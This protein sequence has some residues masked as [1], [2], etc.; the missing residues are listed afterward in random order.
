MPAGGMVTATVG[1]AVIG[2]IMGNISASSS[3]K[4]AAAASRAALAE[5]N[6]I[7]MPPDLSKEIIMK[8]FESQGILTPD[9]EQEI[10]LQASEVSQIKED[11]S[12]RGAQ[13]E[14]L[15]T[16]GQ[17]SRGGLQAGDRQAY[18]EL[19]ASTQRDAEAKRQ[20]ILQQMQM[21]GQG[22]SGASLIAQLQSGQAAEDTA[23]MQGDRLAAQAS[24]NALAALSQRSNLASGMRTQD[25]SAA[26]MRARAID[27]RNRFLAENSVSRQRAN[28]GALN[29][30]QQANLAN[31]QRLSE[32]NTSQANT[33]A[34]RQQQAKRDYFQDQ[35]GLA[36]AKA[37]ALNNQA[38]Q[39]QAA[40]QQKADMWSGL[41]SAVGQGFS[42]YGSANA[43][44]P[45]KTTTGTAGDKFYMNKVD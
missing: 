1:A 3:R 38:S 27:D 30:A 4:Q 37:S 41:G 13:M 17:V 24:Q 40:G 11:P 36:S 29:E 16:L 39:Y 12:L 2:G 8:Q 26:E 5:L 6:K 22:G 35:L 19:R 45:T 7:G 14:A 32:M 44:T 15:N 42:A 43:K 33:E 20:Q 18:N 34:Q 28:V 31:S 9:L 25:M 23:S 10:N 21:Q